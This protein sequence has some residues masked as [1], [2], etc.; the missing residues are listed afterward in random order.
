MSASTAKDRFTA[1]WS[2]PIPAHLSIQ[3]FSAK[4]EA[5]AESLLALPSAQKNLLK[6]DLIIPN[7]KL[8]SY[9]KALGFPE[10]QPVVLEKIDCEVQPTHV[11]RATALTT[12]TTRAQNIVR[13]DTDAMKKISTAQEFASASMFSVDVITKIDAG[14]ADGRDACIG[15]FKCPP[16]LSRTQFHEF[17]DK[18]SNGFAALP[19]MQKNIVKQ[20]MI[21]WLQND[22]IEKDV[23]AMGISAAETVAVFMVQAFFYHHLSSAE[24]LLQ[25]WTDDELRQHFARV[26]KAATNEYSNRFSVNIR[27]SSPTAWPGHARLPDVASQAVLGLIIYPRIHMRNMSAPI[28]EEMIRLRQAD[29]RLSVLSTLASPRKA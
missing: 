25:V 26:D 4:I 14:S 27:F 22:T 10:P 20:T 16:H 8:D 12:V 13:K 29:Q 9:F 23:Q 19:T 2:H 5:Q 15:I 11:V 3:E 28:H 7:N 1:I 18:A 24:Q 17:V 6:Y 21:Q